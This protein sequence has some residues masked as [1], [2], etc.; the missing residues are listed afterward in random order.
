MSKITRPLLTGIVALTATLVAGCATNGSALASWSANPTTP[1]RTVASSAQAECDEHL[2]ELADLQRTD[3]P[4]D[5]VLVEQRG[6]ITTVLT[7]G[8]ASSGYC[9]SLPKEMLAGVSTAAALADGDEIDIVASPLLSGR[10][11]TVHV[12][13]GQATP[14]VDGVSIHTSEGEQVHASLS[15]GWFVAWWPASLDAT[16]VVALDKSGQTLSTLTDLPN[17]AAPPPSPIRR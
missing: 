15:D 10:D 17:D 6:D 13:V 16:A 14:A 9:L 3:L 1:D 12:L 8:A 4:H 2:S 5:P 7:V 11:G